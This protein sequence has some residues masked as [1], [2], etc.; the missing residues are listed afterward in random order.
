MFILKNSVLNLSVLILLI[1]IIEYDCKPLKIG[2]KNVKRQMFQTTTYPTNMT[3]ISMNTTSTH[4]M[5]SYEVT[6]DDSDD[7]VSKSF[8]PYENLPDQ[9]PNIANIDWY[10]KYYG[11]SVPIAAVP[12][13]DRK[14]W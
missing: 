2:S 4:A 8:N 12:N 14:N 7:F 5:I 3:T 10:T 11:L 6:D 13:S 9:T 1:F